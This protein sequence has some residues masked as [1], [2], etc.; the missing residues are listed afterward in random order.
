[1]REDENLCQQ[2]KNLHDIEE[3]KQLKAR[4]FR[5]L[6]Q[7][8]WDDWKELFTPDLYAQADGSTFTNRE[9][10]VGLVAQLLADVESAHQ[11]HMPE[12]RIVDKD[13][14][15]GI[16]ALDDVLRFP[17]DP[18]PG[19]HGKGR[20]HEKYVRT[21]EGWKIASTV[22]TRLYPVDPLPGGYPEGGPWPL[23]KESTPQG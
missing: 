12:I 6:D 7:K 20:Y 2:I 11:G 16:W 22:L 3:I 18:I 13:H 1:M 21:D 4:Y 15:E 17:G 8:R 5:Y 14:A 19:I 23:E 9:T 10:F